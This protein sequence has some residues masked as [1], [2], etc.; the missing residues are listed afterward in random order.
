VEQ[1]PR[2]LVEEEARGVEVPAEGTP[3]EVFDE[4]DAGVRRAGAEGTLIL[5]RRAP[6]PKTRAGRRQLAGEE[7][8]R[9]SGLGKHLLHGM[10]LSA[11]LERRG[12]LCLLG[13][14]IAEVRIVAQP[15]HAEAVPRLSHVR[16]PSVPSITLAATRRR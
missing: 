15:P 5:D 6:L 12:Q 8:Y 9:R 11:R 1:V 10:L 14:E 16:P 4:T 2:S 7:R 3:L 13:S